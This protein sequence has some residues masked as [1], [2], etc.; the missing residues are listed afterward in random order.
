M[1]LQDMLKCQG[2]GKP[3]DAR[4][5]KSTIRKDARSIPRCGRCYLQYKRNERKYSVKK[6]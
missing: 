3:L 4:S 1:K 6:L 5:T 2:C